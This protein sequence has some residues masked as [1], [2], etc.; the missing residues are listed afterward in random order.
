M[1]FKILLFISFFYLLSPNHLAAQKKSDAGSVIA[2]AA[3]AAVVGLFIAGSIESIQE[4]MERNMVEWI[5]ENKNMSSKIG[6]ELKL[7]KWEATKKED[8]SNVS[9]VAYKYTERGKTPI[10]L[11]NACSPGWINDNGINFQ[12]VGVYEIS[13]EYWS[14]MLLNYLNLAKKAELEDVKSIEVIPVIDTKGKPKNTPIY[15][16]LNITSRYFEFVDEN[17]DKTK[18]EFNILVNGDYHIVNKF[19][20]QFTI[21]FNE[22]NMN[23]FLASTKDL[24]RIKRDFIIDITRALY[25]SKIPY[26]NFKWENK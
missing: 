2:A 12:Y 6:F 8:L 7:L 20:D 23:I 4:R 16:L 13:P 3:G 11:L 25:H 21:D 22:G 26:N 17:R 14:K 1:K 18:F 9:V 15:N 10:V 19:D 5:L 24:I